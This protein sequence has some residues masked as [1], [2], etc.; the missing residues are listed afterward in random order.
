MRAL[1]EA[2]WKPNRSR[3]E[4]A[5]PPT[6]PVLTPSF[7]F[8]ISTFFRATFLPVLRCFALN[9]S[10]Q[11]ERGDPRGFIRPFLLGPPLPQLRRRAEKRDSPGGAGPGTQGTRLLCPPHPPAI[12]GPSPSLYFLSSD[13]S[14]RLLLESPLPSQ[15]PLCNPSPPPITGLRLLPASRLR[16]AQAG[17]GAA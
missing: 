9:T 15:A 13:S 4:T 10:L 3:E 14:P 1:A 12:C 8:S 5:G 17:C 6:P 16:Q 2:G 11:A 7:S